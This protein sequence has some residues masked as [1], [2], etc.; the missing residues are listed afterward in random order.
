VLA[1]QIVDEARHLL[2]KVAALD[3][4]DERESRQALERAGRQSDVE[5]ALELGAVPPARSHGHLPAH[6]DRNGDDAEHVGT[7]VAR[8]DA[9]V[10]RPRFLLAVVVDDHDARKALGVE[11]AAAAVRGHK[12][13][14]TE[15]RGRGPAVVVVAETEEPVRDVDGGGGQ[16]ELA[17]VR[18]GEHRARILTVG[19]STEERP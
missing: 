10:V 9:D 5:P 15:V 17:D 1:K 13:A 14:C 11:E 16:R 12:R 6:L 2:A 19:M 7:G 3:D 4:G 8:A 18:L